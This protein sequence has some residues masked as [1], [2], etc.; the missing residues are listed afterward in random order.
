MSLDPA[1]LGDSSTSELA[2]ELLSLGREDAAGELVR[3]GARR[4][5][6][7]ALASA[8]AGQ[9]GATAWSLS[10]AKWFGIGVGVGLVSVGIV[11]AVAPSPTAERAARPRPIPTA[12]VQRE[13]HEAPAVVSI[14]ELPLAPPV[15]MPT[16]RAARSQRPPPDGL[17]REIAI[18]D[19]ARKAVADGT[20]SLALRE[21]DEHSADFRVLAPEAQSL[22]IEALYAS[23]RRNEADAFANRFLTSFPQ[24]PLSARVR[25]LKEA[26]APEVPVP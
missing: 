5:A 19:R 23:G 25:A 21:L 26:H 15:S 2:R 17:E 18:L 13:V 12:I 9:A 20:P 7:Q 16:G 8:L 10:L 14:D 1:R 6:E 24:S 4:A 11:A 22:R 3:Q